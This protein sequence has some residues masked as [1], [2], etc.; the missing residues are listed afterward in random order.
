MVNAIST[1]AHSIIV[2]VFIFLILSGWIVVGTLSDAGLGPDYKTRQ[3][4][5]HMLNG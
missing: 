3:A 2:V 4:N 1:D 5:R